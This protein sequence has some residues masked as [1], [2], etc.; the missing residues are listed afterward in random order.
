MSSKTLK[1]S[2]DG[3]SEISVQEIDFSKYHTKELASR[4]G[5][6]LSLP[7]TMGRLALLIVVCV[8]VG[9]ILIYA[10]MKIDAQAFF[11]TLLA[12]VY[13]FPAC[14]VFAIAVWLVLLINYSLSSLT[15]IVDLMLETT[16][17]VA[18]DYQELGEGGKKLPPMEKLVGSVHEHIFTRIIR[19][20]ISSQTGF[21]GTPIFWVYEKTID[22][23]LKIAIRFVAT[24]MASE[25][26]KQSMKK[27]V[28]ES[29]TNITE[30][31]SQLISSL[32]WARQKIVGSGKWLTRRMLWPCYF[33]IAVVLAV[34]LAPIVAVL[35]FA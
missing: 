10:A 21:L 20:V 27:L 12:E 22:R 23:M 33:L 5:D 6:L 18:Q 32:Q 24:R 29:M 28:T 2:V 4:I 9:M 7:K 31:Q 8:V 25:E 15:K 14:I 34:L 16:V 3:S 26:D 1:E 17:K 35:V 13:A 19:E 30:E 11:V